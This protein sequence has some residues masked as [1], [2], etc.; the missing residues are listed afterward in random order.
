MKNFLTK[1]WLGPLFLF[2]YTLGVSFFLVHKMI[3]YM[4]EIFPVITQEAESFLPITL[5][6]AFLM[7]ATVESS[8]SRPR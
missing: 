6:L 2:L 4:K 1:K 8:L 3:P 7:I 5:L